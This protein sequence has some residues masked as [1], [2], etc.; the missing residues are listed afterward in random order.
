[1]PSQ[2]PRHKKRDTP[3]PSEK[4]LA[5]YQAGEQ[6]LLLPEIGLYLATETGK[7]GI[8][9]KNASIEGANRSFDRRSKGLYALPPLKVPLSQ[10]FFQAS[11]GIEGFL[12]FVVEAVRKFPYGG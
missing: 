12:G 7:R 9:E 5:L 3:G 10:D 6:N 4:R 11:C 1:M 8:A 2:N